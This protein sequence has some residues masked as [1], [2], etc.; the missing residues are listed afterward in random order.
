M[1][2][3]F[4]QHLLQ[5]CWRQLDSRLDQLARQISDDNRRTRH[6]LKMQEVRFKLDLAAAGIN[7][8]NKANF[9][10]FGACQSLPVPGVQSGGRAG[11]NPTAPRGSLAINRAIQHSLQAQ[12]QALWQLQQR[13][14][15]L[16]GGR[17]CEDRDNP[18]APAALCLAF[19]RAAQD[20]DVDTQVRLALY[21][22]FG[23]LFVQLLP[24]FYQDINRYLMSVGVLPNLL[25]VVPQKP[26][27]PSG[28]GASA[29]PESSE[30][31]LAQTL[32]LL[33]GQLQ[34]PPGIRST[35]DASPLLGG[36]SYLVACTLLQRQIAA[37]VDFQRDQ[38]IDPESTTRQYFK[39]LV[40]QMRRHKANADSDVLLAIELVTR[41][42]Q[43]VCN[44]P[45]VPLQLRCLLSFLHAPSL[46]LAITEPDYLDSPQHPGRRLLD[47][48]LLHGSTWLL[49]AAEDHSMLDTMRR[50]AS[51]LACDITHN[52]AHFSQAIEV[53]EDSIARLEMSAVQTE[54]REVQI[55]AGMQRL[56]EARLQARERVQAAMTH[57]HVSPELRE[58][59]AGSC[60]DFL[61]FILL[62]HGEG[63]HWVQAQHLLKGIALSVR[64][65]AQRL[66]LIQFQR[67]QQRLFRAV[68]K[69]LSEAGYAG[70]LARDLLA[71]LQQAQRQLVEN[72]AIADS[73]AQ[74]L[75]QAAHPS[76]PIQLA[77]QLL[78]GHWYK[79]SDRPDS[80]PI[81]LKLAWA[82]RGFARALFVDASGSRRR[83]EYADTLEKSI[84][85]NQLLRLS[86]DTKPTSGS[87]LQSVFHQLRLNAL[88]KKFDGRSANPRRPE[89]R[90][91]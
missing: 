56:D 17:R 43:N 80:G 19:Q 54:R 61:T 31:H 71:S 24:G 25:S 47:L 74:P 50:V 52:S 42:F 26:V 76:A 28:D 1:A 8:Q 44:N 84:G 15:L 66:Q 48:L 29:Q 72:F 87:A 41:L 35:L 4:C 7:R 67:G 57:H 81:E 85:R 64:T 36:D 13:L 45:D 21:E 23:Q 14:S 65:P 83:L 39:Y 12:H 62:Q 78:T 10:H 38:L 69:G 16:R 3:A 34:W 27:K 37:H 88:R 89:L 77:D 68:D 2:Q 9:K 5:L 91:C 79:F 40:A 46:K 90:I 32:E 59:V 73:D 86:P 70:M 6:Y 63:R 20:L 55:Q 33:R 53:M 49:S 51:T 60:I 58:Q 75:E 11:A 30:S 82:S 18:L 22:I